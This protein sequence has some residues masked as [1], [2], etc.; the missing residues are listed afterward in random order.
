[1]ELPLDMRGGIG[2]LPLTDQALLLLGTGRLKDGL[3]GIDLVTPDGRLLFHREM[4]KHDYVM[5]EPARSDEHGDRFAF[6]VET[7]RGGSQLLDI[8][9]KRVARRVVVYTDTGQELALIPVSTTYHRDFDF[10]MSPDGHRLAILDEG[11]V[12][13]VE[14]E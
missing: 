13:I 7:W 5:G 4:P 11:V 9:G 1:V 14:L 12:T 2:L 8:S 3:R 10:S 6:M